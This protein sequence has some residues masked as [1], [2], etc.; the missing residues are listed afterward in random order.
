MHPLQ[1]LAQRF[2]DRFTA[3]EG[4][5]GIEAIVSAIDTLPPGIVETAIKRYQGIIRGNPWYFPVLQD[6]DLEQFI[7]R[8]ISV[9]ENYF[10]VAEEV[11]TLLTGNG[12][13]DMLSNPR[14][15]ARV[16]ESETMRGWVGKRSPSGLDALLESRVDELDALLTPLGSD[17]DTVFEYGGVYT[18]D[19]NR[20]S[21]ES[22]IVALF[23]RYHTEVGQPLTVDML[24]TRPNATAL[25]LL[26][27][28][29]RYSVSQF[30][31]KYD[32]LSA[33]LHNP[34]P[35]SGDMSDL[36]NNL[37]AKLDDNTR[38]RVLLLLEEVKALNLMNLNYEVKY[39]FKGWAGLM[40]IL[41]ITMCSNTTGIQNDV[42]A[43]RARLEN[44]E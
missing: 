19:P 4:R 37:V 42:Y 30:N 36:V 14:L 11:M 24:R 25:R 40:H 10:A 8:W 26:R 13:L 7:A 29:C 20:V 39:S 16:I 43:M 28:F 21:A 12:S 27:G 18:G 1:T 44:G 23:T 35:Q 34:R 3:L 41:V 32:D 17:A 5:F 38:R 9:H 31:G 33:R 22:E 15:L 2:D 6:V